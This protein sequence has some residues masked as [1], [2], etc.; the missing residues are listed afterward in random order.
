M[1]EKCCQT[2]VQIAAYQPCTQPYTAQPQPYMRTDILLGLE[3][4]ETPYNIA[5]AGKLV[6]TTFAPVFE[7]I[8]G[9]KKMM[10]ILTLSRVFSQH[11]NPPSQ[12]SHHRRVAASQQRASFSAPCSG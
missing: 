6:P 4:S 1:E 2:P 8:V 5:T 12:H 3:P 11:R 7:R 10:P 9:R